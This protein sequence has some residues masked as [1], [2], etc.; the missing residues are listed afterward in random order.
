METRSEAAAASAGAA[1]SLLPP[2]FRAIVSTVVPAATELDGEAWLEVERLVIDSLQQR[3]RAL[4]R[5][6][7]LFL[8]LVQW[9]PA[10]RYGRPFTSLDD[11][12]RARVLA[13]LRDHSIDLIRVGFWGVRTLALLGYYGRDAAA[14]A[15]GYRPRHDGWDAFRP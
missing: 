2:V 9:L 7:R 4:Q 12:R 14:R 6:L 5:R 1:P 10:L 11:E 8:T 15:I 13:R 3:P